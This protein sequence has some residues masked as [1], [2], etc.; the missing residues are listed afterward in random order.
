M[1][2][3][4]RSTRIHPRLS[5][6]LELIRPV[7][8]LTNSSAY[9]ILPRPLLNRHALRT[10]YKGRIFR[11]FNIMKL[12]HQLWMEKYPNI[13]EAR[14]FPLTGIENARPETVAAGHPRMDLSKLPFDPYAFIEKAPEWN[15]IAF[16]REE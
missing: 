13:G 3:T 8:G 7:Y 15:N 16:D 9:T 2:V 1:R 10:C 12:R 5:G 11:R 4:P 14:A 6:Q